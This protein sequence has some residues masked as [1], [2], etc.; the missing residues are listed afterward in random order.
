M[1]YESDWWIGGFLIAFLFGLALTLIYTWFLAPKVPV[2]NPSE[3]TTEDKEIYI[4]LVAAAY[5][6]DKNLEKAERRLARLQ[7][8]NINTTISNLAQ[9]YISIGADSRDIHALV[10]LA[11]ALGET[12]SYMAVYLATPVPTPTATNTPTNIPTS[13]PTA[14]PTITPSATPSPTFSPTPTNS[15]T[16][17][18]TFT[19]RP[20]PTSGPNDSFKLA[21]SVALCDNNANS[22]L[23]VY[24]RDWQG[25]GVP[26]VEVLVSWSGGQ[27]KLVTGF[28][29]EV[30]PG[31][32]D[33]QM[34][35][36][37]VYQVELLNLPAPLA[38]DINKAAQTRCL[39]LAKDISPS[40]QIV[41]QQG[42][43]SN[44]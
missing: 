24:V 14:T 27:N 12:G 22:V 44:N 42:K 36:G 43:A 35:A 5:K 6:H 25:N 4:V 20:S 11:A 34:S 2:T 10:E 8:K 23:R 40:W 38:K 30:N 16:V 41:F 21:Q 32:A 17:R 9:K 7:D 26:G 19:L 29:P 28:K 33:F 39:N 37:E 31:Y 18:P 3:L 15:P 13:T 1:K